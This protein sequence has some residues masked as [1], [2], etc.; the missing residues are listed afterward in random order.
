M[1]TA[2]YIASLLTLAISSHALAQDRPAVSPWNCDRRES[3]VSKEAPL[4]A[5]RISKDS[6]RVRWAAGAT[7]FRDSGVVAG[8]AGGTTYR[9]CGFRE[10]F[11][12]VEKG[13]EELF[14]GILIVHSS[15]KILPAG[16]EVFMAP[17]RSQYL[18]VVQPHGQDGSTWILY[19]TTGA[20]LWKGYAGLIGRPPGYTYDAVLGELVNPHWTSSEELT[21]TFMC[22]GKPSVVALKRVTAKWEWSPKL[23]CNHTG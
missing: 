9:Y 11:H 14:A 4:R 1:K 5:D 20:V 21:A 12:L 23:E 3:E 15:G 22:K 10:G 7:I 19:S 18:A 16:H 13:E 8:D 6:F 17:S 2:L